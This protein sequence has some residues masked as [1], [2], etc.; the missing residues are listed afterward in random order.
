MQIKKKSIQ[1][2]HCI[3]YIDGLSPKAQ[4][5]QLW[6]LD[7]LQWA[8]DPPN[9]FVNHMCYRSANIVILYQQE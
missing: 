4:N 8:T 2:L 6:G 3:L 5:Q 1:I 7:K 9:T